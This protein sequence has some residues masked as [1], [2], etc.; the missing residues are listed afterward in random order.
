MGHESQ[1][2]PWSPFEAPFWLAGF[3]N[4]QASSLSAMTTA[5]RENQNLWVH[6]QEPREWCGRSKHTLLTQRGWK[7]T[8]IPAM[9]KTFL[10]TFPFIEQVK[11]SAE[12]PNNSGE[13]VYSLSTVVY[14]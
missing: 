14:K 13:K 10:L 7:V 11:Y 1:I 12:H 5:T 3:G 2:E 4:E 9:G 8:E 6:A